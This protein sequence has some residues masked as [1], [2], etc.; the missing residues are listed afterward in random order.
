M[1]TNVLSDAKC[2]SAKPRE[3]PYKLFDG[4]GL[5]LLVNPTGSKL[6]RMAYRLNGKPQTATFGPYPLVTLAEAREK[7]DEVRKTLLAGEAPKKI[8]KRDPMTLKQANE[9]YWAGRQDIT[10]GYRDNATKALAQHVEPMLGSRDIATIT[11][12]DMLAALMVM[13]AAGLYDYVR[14][15]RMWQGMVFEWGIEQGRC[16]VNPCATIKPEKAF[17]K[18]T[19][20]HFPALSLAEMP[21][22]MARLKLQK[23][24]QS[25]IACKLLALTWT[26]TVELRGMQWSEIDGDLWRIPKERMKKKRDHLVP[27]SKQAVELIEHMK[28]R[29]KG[30]VYVFPSDRRLDR[31]MSENS[32]LYLLHRM[33]YRGRMT[34]HG[35]RTVASTWANE[36]GYKADAIE[37]QLSHEPDNEV[38]AAYNR[39]EYLPERRAMIQAFSDWLCA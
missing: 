11:R 26:R 34:G 21:E 20:E 31:P 4:H 28:A 25:A 3:K 16:Q 35:F 23:L 30:S 2:K 13:D 24:I 19:V 27:L 8:I 12:E 6:W 10:P 18:K 15:V 1:P 9:A 5:F 22:F 32:I 33:E 38:R 17:G 14:K 29:S 7:R 39:A 36:N 37:R